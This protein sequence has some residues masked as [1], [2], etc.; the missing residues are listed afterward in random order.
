MS[1]RMNAGEKTCKSTAGSGAVSDRP[2]EGR[3]A[4][5]TV[6]DTVGAEADLLGG[7]CP[8]FQVRT[9]SC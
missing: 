6:G 4:K 1:S 7:T 9:G 8:R 5:R 3:E 2:G